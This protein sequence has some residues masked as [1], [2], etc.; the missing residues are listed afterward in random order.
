M[1]AWRVRCLLSRTKHSGPDLRYVLLDVSKQQFP[2]DVPRSNEWFKY[3]QQE[4]RVASV[5]WDYD[6]KLIKINLRD[7]SL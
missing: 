4:Y 5:V 2:G 1:K 7:G 3:D 6:E